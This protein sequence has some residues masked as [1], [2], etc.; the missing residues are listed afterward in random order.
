M[1][2]DYC[3]LVVQKMTV[4][5]YIGRKNKTRCTKK[6]TNCQTCVSARASFGS[7][8]IEELVYI[9]YAKRRKNDATIYKTTTDRSSQ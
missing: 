4:R 3:K 2:K 6:K 1:S 8:C 7:D 5:W 9:K